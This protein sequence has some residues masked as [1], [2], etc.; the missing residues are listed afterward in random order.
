M[1]PPLQQEEGSDHYW[2]EGAWNSSIWYV[3]T[4]FLS[5]RQQNYNAQVVNAVWGNNRHSFW[6]S[7]KLKKCTL[8][9]NCRVFEVKVDGTYGYQL[10]FKWIRNW[11]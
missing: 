10:C 5:H 9:A 1:G 7:C 3:W 2:L 8:W 11:K 6:E 4:E